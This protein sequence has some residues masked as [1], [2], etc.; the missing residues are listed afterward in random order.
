MDDEQAMSVV[1]TLHYVL[2]AFTALAAMFG[3]PFVVVGARL[4]NAA[5]AGSIPPA[6][7]ASA[8]EAV[9]QGALLIAAGATIICLC[10]VHAAVVAYIGRLIQ[11]RRRRLLCLVFSILHLVNV[12]LGT[13]LSILTLAVLKRPG[14]RKRFDAKPAT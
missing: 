12:P 6:T 5:G 2:A 4:L 9:V 13:A 1:A 14:V 3:V 10:L 7:P 8:D 11:H